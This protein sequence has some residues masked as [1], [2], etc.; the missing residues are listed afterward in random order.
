MCSSRRIRATRE[1]AA[2]HGVVRQ[3]RFT[4]VFG[5]QQRLSLTRSV[6]AA[7]SKRNAGLHPATVAKSSRA[8]EA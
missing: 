3:K 1:Y 4:E 7:Q 5:R 2:E 8:E 6:I